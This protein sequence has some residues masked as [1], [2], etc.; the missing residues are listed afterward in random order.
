MDVNSKEISQKMKKTNLCEQW[1]S[2]TSLHIL[3]KKYL[4]S[5]SN[6]KEMIK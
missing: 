1:C 6:I 2:T 3:K 4:K 5:V